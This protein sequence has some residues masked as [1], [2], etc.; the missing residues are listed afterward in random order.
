LKEEVKESDSQVTE[1]AVKKD[2]EAILPSSTPSEPK[3]VP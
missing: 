1:T 3:K 2:D